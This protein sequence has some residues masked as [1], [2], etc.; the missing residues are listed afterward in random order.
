MESR[1]FKALI[2]AENKYKGNDFTAHI[3]RSGPGHPSF[4]ILIVQL[5]INEF[6]VMVVVWAVHLIGTY[7]ASESRAE[8]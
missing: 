6:P 3:L 1:D 7:P 4:C 2:S 8:W 5:L